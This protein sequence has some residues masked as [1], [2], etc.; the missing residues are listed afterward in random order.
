MLS[1]LLGAQF[2]QCCA[3]CLSQPITSLDGK[4]WIL[5]IASRN[6]ANAAA[7][8]GCP[9]SA[10]ENRFNTLRSSGAHGVALS[11]GRVHS[12]PP[13]AHALALSSQEV[14]ENEPIVNVAWRMNLRRF[15]LISSFSLRN[16]WNQ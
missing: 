15:M 12:G 8:L 11:V 9:I 14:I 6:F 2:R 4:A 7:W 16:L 5:H 10:V 1:G 3:I 13:C